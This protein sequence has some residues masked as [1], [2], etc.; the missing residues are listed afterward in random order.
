MFT[1]LGAAFLTT[2]AKLAPGLTSR[3]IGVVWTLIPGN[4]G[5]SFPREIK[6]DMATT[7]NMPAITDK[8]PTIG[9]R[10]IFVK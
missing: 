1:T 9:I 4:G 6:Q 2:G 8:N 10:F 5:A 7:V 3:L